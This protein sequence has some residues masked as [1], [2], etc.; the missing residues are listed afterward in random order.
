MV[1]SL[2]IDW[3]IGYWKK[4]LFTKLVLW[5]LM[6]CISW[7]I[8]FEVTCLNCCWLR[9]STCVRSECLYRCCFW[10]AYIIWEVCSGCKA[11]MVVQSDFQ[12]DLFIYLF[13]Y[14]FICGLFNDPLNDLYCGVVNFCWHRLM[15]ILTG[16]ARGSCARLP[17]WDPFP[18]YR[19]SF[20]FVLTV[21]T[22]ANVLSH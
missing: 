19:Y 5:L 4:G 15:Y 13:I 9:Y 11:S 7:A 3:Y 8:L 16:E 18:P 14:L 2:L 6:S 22:R 17:T 20:Q 10:F 21:C 12:D 1:D